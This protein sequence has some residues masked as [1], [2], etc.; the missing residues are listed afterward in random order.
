MKSTFDRLNLRPF[1]RRLVVGVGTVVFIV[2]NM[3]FVWPHFSARG[4]ALDNLEATR[5]L[6]AKFEKE[7][8]EAP[9]SQRKVRAL[10]SEAEPVPPEDQGL[11]F[12]RTIQT[13]AAQSGVTLTGT[14]R[15]TIR[16]NSQFFIERSQTITIVAAEQQ[17]VD[18]LFNI[19]AAGSM[20]RA[21]DLSLRPDAPR[22]HLGGSVKLVASYQKKAPPKPAPA[23]TASS[24]PAARPAEKPAAKPAEKPALKPADKPLVKP[25]VTTTGVPQPN[26]ADKAVLPPG[27]GKPALMKPAPPDQRRP[28][29]GR[30]TDRPAN[31]GPGIQPPRPMPMPSKPGSATDKPTNEQE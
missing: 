8:G 5:K 10:E 14:S 26:P 11:Q 22:Q 30:G 16:T 6:L 2:L 1:E 23:A 25:A 4:K 19:G 18:F 15:E 21:R 13:Q 24:K 31:A 28:M 7:V 12:L 27:S 3:V 20:I 29:P 9:E 17:L